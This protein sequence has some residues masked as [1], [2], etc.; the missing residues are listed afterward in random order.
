MEARRAALQSKGTLQGPAASAWAP[1]KPLSKS[2]D[3]ATVSVKV[4]CIS[5]VAEARLAASAGA[6]ALGLGGCRADD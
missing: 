3:K 2:S 1:Q 4:C 6:A 5:S